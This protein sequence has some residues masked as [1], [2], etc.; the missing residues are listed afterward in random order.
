MSQLDAA[1]SAFTSPSTP[2]RNLYTIL[3]SPPSPSP[4]LSSSSSSFG[5]D[6]ST[7]SHDGTSTSQPLTP[8]TT[9]MDTM[10]RLVASSFHA[11]FR[12][13]TTTTT[14]TTT[15]TATATALPMIT[16]AT[17]ADPTTTLISPPSVLET[18]PGAG[19]LLAFALLRFV[20]R[21]GLRRAR[22][23]FWAVY[24]ANQ[25]LMYFIYITSEIMPPWALPLLSISRRAH[26]IFLLRLFN[27]GLATLCM[28]AGYV[29]MPFVCLFV[30]F[31]FAS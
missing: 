11:L 20:T 28:T 6:S 8:T 3:S 25:I 22:L 26:S 13:S 10:S 2:S 14:T 4:P 9:M 29:F 7:F 27:D 31:Y 15:A 24:M 16:Q 17:S 1:L 12:I 30:L 18:V 19:H 23:V 21:G 5:V